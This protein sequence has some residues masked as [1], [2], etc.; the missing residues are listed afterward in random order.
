MMTTKDSLMGLLPSSWSLNWNSQ[1]QVFSL[2]LH[3]IG[4]YF[5]V[6]QM[7]ECENSFY[8]GGNVRTWNSYSAETRN[9][10]D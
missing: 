5:Q 6:D 7:L 2:V 4:G 10:Y 9:A 8:L 1:L 3:R